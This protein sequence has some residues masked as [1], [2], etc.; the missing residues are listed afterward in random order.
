LFVRSERPSP[1]DRVIAVSNS[2]LESLRRLPRIESAV[3]AAILPVDGNLWVP[4]I[5]IQG[6]S[7]HPG[8]SD[9]AFNVVSPGYFT[10]LRTPILAGREFDAHDTLESPRVVVVNA[11]FVRYFF[12]NASA[13]GRRVKYRNRLYEIVGIAG[14][15]KYEDLRSAA[16]R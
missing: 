14:D 12:G 5:E 2:L 8:D 13:L 15:A 1:D 10:T 16:P 6:D 7:L 4:A 9:A 11:A 3:A